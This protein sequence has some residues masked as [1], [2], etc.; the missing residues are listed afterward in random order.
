VF[1][2]VLGASLAKKIG[3]PMS[4]GPQD[5]ITPKFRVEFTR[6]LLRNQQLEIH[7]MSFLRKV[8]SRRPS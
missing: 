7:K 8:Q 6:K 2:D 3:V 1:L 4:E 5:V